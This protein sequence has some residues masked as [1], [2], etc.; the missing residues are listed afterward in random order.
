[1]TGIYDDPPIKYEKVIFDQAGFHDRLHQETTIYEG[2]P[3]AANNASW[4]RLM[5]GR[6]MTVT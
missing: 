5:S 4:D 2:Q 3:D 1:M 6:Y